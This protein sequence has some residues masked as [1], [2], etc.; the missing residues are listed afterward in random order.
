M[1][2]VKIGGG[3][4]INIKGVVQ[5]LSGLEGPVIIVQGANAVRDEIAATLGY[6]TKTVTSASGY[7]SVLSDAKAIDI[8]MMAYAGI[9]NK[10]LVELCQQHGINAVGLSG[11]DGR[12]VQGTRN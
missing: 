2:I 6:P 12:V 3:K 8:I 11:I 5:D 7:A 10:R 4:G 9:Q 1:I